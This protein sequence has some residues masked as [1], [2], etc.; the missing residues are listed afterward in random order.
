MLLGF[1]MINDLSSLSTKAGA[2]DQI[3]LLTFRMAC[4]LWGGTGSGWI[5]LLE[6]IGLAFGIV[7]LFREDK[8]LFALLFCL[9]C[10]QWLA[11]LSL[12]PDTIHHGMTMARYGLVTLPMGL[13]LLALTL[14]YLENR[15]RI[16]LSYIPFGLMGLLASTILFIFGPLPST[17]RYP[18]NWTN[19]A[20]YQAFYSLKRR[21]IY[22]VN[23]LSARDLPVFYHQLG[24]ETPGTM[25]IVEAPWYMDWHHTPYP[26]YQYFHRQ[27]MAIGFIQNSDVPTV[28][29]IPLHDSKLNFWN[30][31]H[32]A[33]HEGLRQRNVQFVILHRDLRDEIP[34]PDDKP[35]CSI[36]GWIEV[37][38]NRYGSPCYEDEL[39][40]VFDLKMLPK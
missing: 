37:Y 10:L 38:K 29:E 12:Y 30:F 35:P 34:K 20:L 13:F 14:A 16:V 1:P 2:G 23:N 19:H 24:Q 33:D 27:K 7:L 15:L 5:L 6:A 22:A 11:I 28:D 18:N 17:Y 40:V 31:V 8:R 9:F 26:I 25:R 39:M 3:T 36:N 4:E 32:L 21:V